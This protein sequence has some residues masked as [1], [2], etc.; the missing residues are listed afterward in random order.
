[1][2]NEMQ[3]QSE[4][5][6]EGNYFVIINRA[7][8]KLLANSHWKNKKFEEKNSLDIIFAIRKVVFTC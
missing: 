2:G 3:I 5:C 4:H 6:Y 7:I 1:M 8:H